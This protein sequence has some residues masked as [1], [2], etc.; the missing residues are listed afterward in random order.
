MAMSNNRAP[1]PENEEYWPPELWEWFDQVAAYGRKVLQTLD[2][3]DDEQQ[4]SRYQEIIDDTKELVRKMK[5][6]ERLNSNSV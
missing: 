1:K 4:R 6:E 2:E 3:I 5:E